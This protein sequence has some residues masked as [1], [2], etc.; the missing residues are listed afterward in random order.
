MKLWIWTK[1]PKGLWNWQAEK[2]FGQG[3]GEPE[4]HH[5]EPRKTAKVVKPG[6]ENF[7]HGLKKNKKTG[8]YR[9]KTNF[10]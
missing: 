10:F 9:W 5:D 6:A 1:L 4:K 2:S 3:I 7:P 8:K